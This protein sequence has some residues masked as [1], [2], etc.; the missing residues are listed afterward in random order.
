MAGCFG[1]FERQRLWMYPADPRTWSVTLVRARLTGTYRSY[2]IAPDGSVS[3]QVGVAIGGVQVCL[4]DASRVLPDLNAS[5]LT[6]WRARLSSLLISRTPTRGQRYNRGSPWTRAKLRLH[7]EAPHPWRMRLTKSAR[8][9][10]ACTHRR[11]R[12]SPASM[13]SSP[14]GLLQQARSSARYL[15]NQAAE[16]S[17]GPPAITH[18]QV[19]WTWIG[20]AGHLAL[21][22]LGKVARR[23]SLEENQS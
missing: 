3:S 4:G 1:L 13:N 10:N 16:S 5:A 14:P 2:S 12:W 22:I 21:G 9:D 11:Y 18:G 23:P 20:V 8:S 19:L 15:Y 17:N 6:G 7:R